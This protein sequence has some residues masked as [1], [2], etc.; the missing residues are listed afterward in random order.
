ML[1]AMILQEYKFTIWQTLYN[2]YTPYIY[3]Y[4]YTFEY[5][6]YSGNSGVNISTGCE[7]RNTDWIDLLCISMEMFSRGIT[8]EPMSV[9]V[10]SGEVEF[11]LFWWDHNKNYRP[12]KWQNNPKINGRA[13]LTLI[14]QTV[15]WTRIVAMNGRLLWRWIT[16]EIPILGRFQTSDRSMNMKDNNDERS[17]ERTVAAYDSVN[18]QEAIA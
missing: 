4:V 12:N 10:H 14:F 5:R 2:V 13:Q 16:T 9:Y 17:P 18:F 8:N 11:E 15:C 6:K 7:N 1:S 3:I